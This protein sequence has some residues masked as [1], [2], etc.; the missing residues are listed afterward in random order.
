MGCGR[1]PVAPG[2]AS[3]GVA[4]GAHSAPS[5]GVSIRVSPSDLTTETLNSIPFISLDDPRD[6]IPAAER[7]EW[8]A[9]VSLVSLADRHRVETSFDYVPLP[10]AHHI[11]CHEFF[12]Q[13]TEPLTAGWYAVVI[14]GVPR[15]H[16]VITESI[17]ESEQV[18]SRFRVD[19]HPVVL[20]GNLTSLENAS[21]LTIVASE[22]LVVPGGDLEVRFDGQAVR[23]EVSASRANT[24]EL[25]ALR[26]HGDEVVAAA[27]TTDQIVLSCPHAVGRV[28]ELD[29]PTFATLH[30]EILRGTDDRA[31]SHLTLPF[32]DDETVELRSSVE[33]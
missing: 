8:R 21:I 14:A 3:L 20:R 19:S 25:D 32:G 1:E 10:A 18:I 31:G 27:S 6:E 24:D 33:L 12:L 17:R 13:P 2:A 4:S 7:E 11:P 15:G 23:C 9:R 30:G 22:R 5:D 26:L 28:V 29:V 16:A